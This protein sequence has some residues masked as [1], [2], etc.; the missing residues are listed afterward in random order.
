LADDGA[1]PDGMPKP[2]LEELSD[3]TDA[4]LATVGVIGLTGVDI[5]IYT[6]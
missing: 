2:S 5:G 4:E 1:L 6:S 3:N